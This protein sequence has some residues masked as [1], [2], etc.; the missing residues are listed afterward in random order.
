LGALA[1]VVSGLLLVPAAAAAMM[2]VFMFDAPGSGASPLTLALAAGLFAAPLL[3]AYAAAKGIQV[4][5]DP[6]RTGLVAALAVPVGVN[7]CL[8]TLWFLI[9]KFCGG[10]FACG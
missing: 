6:N 7:V 1:A 10:E 3:Y 2:S 9:E 8:A 4:S 5:K